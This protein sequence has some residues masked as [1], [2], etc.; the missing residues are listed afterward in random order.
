MPGGYALGGAPMAQIQA[1]NGAL[2]GMSA[3][4]LASVDAS[5]FAGALLG[6][7]SAGGS[8]GPGGL[9]FPAGLGAAGTGAAS[10]INSMLVAAAAHE[11]DGQTS[12]NALLNS[13]TTLLG[14]GAAGGESTL[15]GGGM[16]PG[17]LPHGAMDASGLL[18]QPS[19]IVPPKRRR[20]ATFGPDGQL[21]AE[22]DEDPAA[23][24]RRAEAN[25]ALRERRRQLYETNPE[26]AEVRRKADA[27]RHRLARARLREENPDLAQ[28]LK[29]AHAARRKEKREELARMNPEK[30]ADIRRKDAERHRLARQKPRSDGGSVGAGG[31]MGPVPDDPGAAAAAAAAMAGGMPGGMDGESSLSA[32]LAGGL[33]AVGVGAGI[34]GAPLPAMDGSIVGAGVE[35]GVG[36]GVGGM[37]GAGGATGVLLQAPSA[38][39]AHGAGGGGRGR[40]RGGASSRGKR[41]YASMSAVHPGSAAAQQAALNANTAA[42]LAAHAAHHQ[43]QESLLGDGGA[44]PAYGEGSA[45]SMHHAASSIMGG[46]QLFP[47]MLGPLAGLSQAE[48]LATLSGAGGALLPQNLAGLAGYPGAAG[49]GGSSAGAGGAGS[50]LGQHLQLL[51]SAGAGSV[52]QGL[53]T[54]SAGAAADA[55]AAGA[56]SSSSS[57]ADGAAGGEAAGQAGAGAGEEDDGE[58]R[59]T[60][61]GLPA[62]KRKRTAIAEEAAQQALEEAL[63]APRGRGRPR[64]SGRGR[65]SRGG[66]RLS[67][68][69][70]GS[71]PTPQQHAVAAHYAAMQGVPMP[72]LPALQ[73]SLQHASMA[74]MGLD[75]AAVAAAAGPAMAAHSAMLGDPAAHAAA[76]QASSAAGVPEAGAAAAPEHQHQQHYQQQQHGGYGG[77][78]MDH[79][80]QQQHQQQMHYQQQYEAAMQHQAAAA[81]AAAPA[82]ETAPEAVAEAPAP[83]AAAGPGGE[84]AAGGAP[85]PS[86]HGDVEVAHLLVRLQ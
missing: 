26:L 45:L 78:A 1:A 56:A 19:L 10:A 70:A 48:A 33:D 23:A 35:G 61:S 43:Q 30:A 72:S 57:A 8:A 3:H 4:P 47:A 59:L 24:Q 27:E 36:V 55:A 51:G 42:M 62:R 40:G 20:R 79:H 18:L 76:L 64:G 73:A 69:S 44:G 14:S 34:P 68:G 71:L 82:P 15:D 38:L 5:T 58:P 13:L 54:A 52:M 28:Q 2:T 60:A 84:G 86:G 50:L 49:A 66:G 29:A 16:G 80:Y 65:G 25:A 6:M 17:G 63:E 22:P 12:N 39:A 41:S 85:K 31:G 67:A 37:P 7:N 21:I 77:V 83:A 81:A 32:L 46:G 75:P 9:P 74:H 53:T 11:V